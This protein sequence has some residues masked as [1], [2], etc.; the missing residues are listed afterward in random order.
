[1]KSR[2]AYQVITIIHNVCP[3][4]LIGSLDYSSG[5]V[6][7]WAREGWIALGQALVQE[8]G[9]GS[10]RPSLP[11][12]EAEQHDCPVPRQSGLS[13]APRTHSGEHSRPVCA[14]LGKGGPPCRTACRV[15][16]GPGPLRW[17]CSGGASRYERP[18]GLAVHGPHPGAAVLGWASV[19]WERGGSQDGGG[20]LGQGSAEFGRQTDAPKHMT[21]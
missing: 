2:P 17:H 10:G 6:W 21:R 12:P 18:H 4:W 13:T 8:Q 19:V 1:M 14:R 9:L 5:A 3:W 11:D 15:P 16:S 7:T 20:G